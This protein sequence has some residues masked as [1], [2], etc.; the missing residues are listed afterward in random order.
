MRTV[1]LKV[2]DPERMGVDAERRFKVEARA[3]AQLSHENLVKLF[4]FGVA[5]D[6]RPFYAMELLTGESLDKKLER[7]RGMDYREAV[8]IAVQACYALET[9]HAAHV[10]HRDIKPANLFLSEDGKLKL[11][12]FGVAKAAFNVEADGE[13]L[14]IVGT[15]EY[16]APEQARGSADERSDI[17]ALG[18]V[19]FELLS[20]HLPH[21][22]E[23][24]VLLLDA[25]FRKEPAS[26]RTL[27]PERGIPK[28]LDAA[29]SR[30]LSPEP[31]HRY[32][33]AAELRIA[34]EAALNEPE[35]ATPRRKLVV[36]G[37]AS[38]IALSVI[39]VIGLAG[40]KPE[41]RQRVS[42]AMSPL[43]AKVEALRTRAAERM[44]AAH[45]ESARV[46]VAAL[47]LDA[48]AIVTVEAKPEPAAAALAPTEAVAPAPFAQ[49]AQA[50]PAASDDGEVEDD[51][52]TSDGADKSE[53][54]SKDEVQAKADPSAAAAD[55]I[56]EADKLSAAGNKVKALNVLRHAAKK[57]PTDTKL[58]QELATM[59]EQNRAW[60]E[61]VRVARRLVA[62]DGSA[63][64]KLEL[65]RLE[66]KTGHRAR[67]LELARSVLKDNPDSP[68]A[69]TMLS[70]LGVG[71]RVAQK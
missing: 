38:A 54:A 37:L 12:D 9:A 48:P 69:H 42:V 25:K 22:G 19:L 40:T 65:A 41:V 49:A 66:R 2:L 61:A 67:A 53:A 17:Y 45:P 13:G 68:E 28:M 71:E 51:S 35:T 44:H 3:I 30:T 11:L 33:S 23:S 20:G 29:V 36:R 56:A 6:G 58:L 31:E 60:G 34:L 32:R 39:A 21:E 50:A 10:I 59:A 70:Q 5:Q 27:V 55:A 26:L 24:P 15:P 62:V 47:K 64:S 18:V 46:Q 52:A 57:A 8:R 16:M 7:E 43:I 1:A 4:E 14:Q 63:D